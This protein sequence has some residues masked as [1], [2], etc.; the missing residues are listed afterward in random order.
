[1][2]Q[3]SIRDQKST[4]RDFWEEAMASATKRTETIRMRKTA[5]MGHKRKAKLA[6]NGTTK[7]RAELFG[8]V[9]K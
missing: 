2:I 3:S 7:K 1:M 5:K 8:D 6:T 4:E 9:T